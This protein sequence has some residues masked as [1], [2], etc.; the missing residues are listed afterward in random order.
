[1]RSLLVACL[2]LGGCL[3]NTHRIPKG[4][5]MALS[6]TAPAERG[7]S[8]RVIQGF[9]GDEGPPAAP[10]VHVGVAVVVTPTHSHSPARRSPAP[11]RSQSMDNKFWI[12]AAAIGALALTFSEG[13][14]YDG[15]VELHP[16]HPV[17][18]Y[19][20]YGEYTWI[21][22][23]QID[24]ETAAWASR[25]YV[26]EGEGPWNRLGRAPLDRVG[27]TYGL[28]LGASELPSSDGSERRGFMGHIQLG[29]FP[30]QQVG[31]LLDFALGW[32]ENEL[33]ATVTDNRNSL[34]LQIIPLEA[35]GFHAGGFG[36]VGLAR[37]LQDHS[38]G[39]GA[40]GESDVLYGGGAIL[41]LDL[42][43]RLALTGRAGVAFVYDEMVTDFTVGLSIY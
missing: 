29:G 28:L 34:E 31:I 26:R 36:Q 37:R 39:P 4:D 20:P 11:A 23:A 43:T 7:R 40:R 1:M 18:L 14:R 12:V 35:G 24:P 25:A 16:M 30:V 38:D 15:W 41:Q 10:G 2:A 22:L 8:V 19:G 3:S 21:P 17:H 13:M 33:G 9:A 42:T 32:G 27:L 6:Q 5:L